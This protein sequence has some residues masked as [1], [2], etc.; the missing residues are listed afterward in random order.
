MLE[1][2]LAPLVEG[3]IVI[4]PVCVLAILGK[5]FPDKIYDKENDDDK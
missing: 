3:A 1:Y 5:Y 4:V 2:V